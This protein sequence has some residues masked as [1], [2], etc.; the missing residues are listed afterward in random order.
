[1][2]AFVAVEDKRFYDHH[3]VDLQSTAKAVEILVRGKLGESTGVERG[4]ST[5]TQQMVK[6]VF[7]S[8]KKTYARK[9]KEIFLALEVEKKY[10]KKEILEFYINNVYFYNNCYG[11]AFSGTIV[12]FKG[13]RS[14]H[15]S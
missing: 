5:I 1:M 3:G 4:G 8:N 12:L 11:I 15:F 6:N 9:L 2:N 10:S 14:A 7:L 13:F